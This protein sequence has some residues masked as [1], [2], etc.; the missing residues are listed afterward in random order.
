MSLAQVRY[1]RVSL[2]MGV[3]GALRSSSVSQL[4]MV[5]ER[6]SLRYTIRR[7][8]TIRYTSYSRSFV[9]I[10]F[11][12]DLFSW[13]RSLFCLF[14]SSFPVTHVHPVCGV[15]MPTLDCSRIRG[16]LEDVET[17]SFYMGFARI[18]S[19]DTGAR[20]ATCVPRPK[21]NHPSVAVF[22][23]WS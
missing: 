12:F 23:T 13:L 6:M 3:R 19:G 17:V 16:R 15:A 7:Y 1:G 5:R 10:Y 9:Y 18:R 14:H 8:D 21:A 4:A 20:V 11:T 22:S 2:S